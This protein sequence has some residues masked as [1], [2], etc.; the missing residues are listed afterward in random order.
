LVGEW[1]K[2]QHEIDWLTLPPSR[3][4]NLLLDVCFYETGGV[5]TPTGSLLEIRV[6]FK[7][8]HEIEKRKAE[9]K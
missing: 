5:C 2:E 4:S 8:Q 6:G 9:R 3:G 1:I 7:V